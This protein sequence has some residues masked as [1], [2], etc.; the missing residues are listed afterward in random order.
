[1][2]EANRVLA[3]LG[4]AAVLGAVVLSIAPGLVPA[5]LRGAL[6]AVSPG[7]YVALLVLV[8]AAVLLVVARRSDGPRAAPLYDP[9]EPTDRPPALGERFDATLERATHPELPRGARIDH[10]DAV[11]EWLRESA[12]NAVVRATDV[13]RDSAAELVASGQW[14]DDRRASAL[15]G[16]DQA[17]AP[18]WYVHLLDLLA[19]ESAFTRRVRH[20]V[21]EIEAVGDGD[22][23][24]GPGATP[25]PAD[26]TDRGRPGGSEPSAGTGPAAGAEPP[27]GVGGPGEAETDGGGRSP[28]G[29]DR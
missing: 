3:G 15:L 21:D 26:G 23:Q 7:V 27:A 29:A 10:Q 14:T 4:A 13:D 1:M 25:G 16:D 2:T 5:G 20:A 22:R 24:P 18:P 17:P 19:P 28:E 11:R 12:T 8:G 6:S 9:P